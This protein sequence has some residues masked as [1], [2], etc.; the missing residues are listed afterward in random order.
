MKPL[1]ELFR[2]AVD[3]GENRAPTSLASNDEREEEA[4]AYLQVSHEG[5]APGWNAQ[6]TSPP[7]YFPSCGAYS[8]RCT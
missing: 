8:R 4:P 3:R 5:G 2:N 1:V 6:S 7:K